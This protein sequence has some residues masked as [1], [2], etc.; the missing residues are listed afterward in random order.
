MEL[1]SAQ[2]TVRKGLFEMDIGKW[3]MGKGQCKPPI[4]DGHLS[5]DIR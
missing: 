5:L 1:Y 4:N 2:L 3:T